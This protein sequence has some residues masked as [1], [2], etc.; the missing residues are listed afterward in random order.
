[1]EGLQGMAERDCLGSG[2]K[3]SRSREISGK[4]APPQEGTKASTRN[5]GKVPRLHRS[6]GTGVYV[7]TDVT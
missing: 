3:G 7:R 4:M 1:M 6:S 2:K 5:T